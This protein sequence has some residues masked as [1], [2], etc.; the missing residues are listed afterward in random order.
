MGPVNLPILGICG[1][2][3]HIPSSKLPSQETGG[4]GEEKPGYLYL[5]SGLKS[6]LLAP[7]CSL[8]R[9][10]PPSRWRPSKPGSLSTASISNLDLLRHLEASC[11]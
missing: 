11:Q 3:L 5:T 4:V 9:V 1:A 2:T 7:C 6:S 10:A 8:A